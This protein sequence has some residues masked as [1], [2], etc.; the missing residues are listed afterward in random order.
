MKKEISL[1]AAVEKIKDGDVILVGGFLAVGGPNRI[2]D[3]IA[4]KTDLKDL[5]IVANDTSFVDKGLGKLIV[6]KKCKKVITS[7]IGTNPETQRQMT[8]GEIEVE[9]VPQGTLA[10]KIRAAGFGLGG[11]LTKTGVGIKEIEEG[12]EKITIDGEEWLLEKPLRGDV[13]LLNAAI[14]DGFGN[15]K[16]IGSTINFNNPMAYAADTVIVEAE[17]LVEV[18]EIDQNQV[19]TP[20]ILVD[21]VVDGGKING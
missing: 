8:E 3:Y 13:A 18:G 7:H 4:E 15:M 21:Y 20:G 9:L 1:E 14:V 11:V 17:K 12:K 16:Y 6:N 19:G 5:T 10:E 2:L